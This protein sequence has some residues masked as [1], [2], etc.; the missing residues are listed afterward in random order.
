MNPEP[1]SREHRECPQ[2]PRPA[3][4][5]AEPGVLGCLARLGDI[6]ALERAAVAM[7]VHPLAA[8]CERAWLL[9][10]NARGELLE[11]RVS[12]AI[13]AAAPPL[14]EWI[15]RSTALRLRVEPPG[16][17]LSVRP[18]RLGGVAGQ[19]WTPGGSAEAGELDPAL[20]WAR[21]AHV[22]AVAL[23]RSGRPWGL[24][25][26]TW[27]DAPAAE[28][29]TALE[30][31]V[32]L[33]TQA[34]AA[35]DQARAAKWR[36][37][38]IASLAQVA[39]AAGSSLNLAEVLQ[40][41]V[42]QATRATGARG[43]ALWAS[44]NSGPRLE[45]MHGPVGSGERTA[46]LL[47]PLVQAVMQDGKVRPVDRTTEEML[48]TPEAAAD[49]DSVVVCPLRAYG[50]VLGALAVYAR[51]PLH[52]SDPSGF[53][54]GDVAFL[55]ALADVAGLALDQ[56]TRF[57]ELRQGEQER[58]ELRRR[59]QRQERLAWLGELAT[60]MAA[61]A[62]NP[63]ASISAF[64]RRV[65][66]AL[67]E[68]DP[69]REYL[70]IVLREGERLETLL[71]ESLGHAPAEGALGLEDLNGVVQEALDAVAETLVRRRVRLV[72]KL[73]TGLPTLLLDRERIRRVVANMLHGALEAVGV[74][75]RVRLESRG[76][77]AC[78]VL[79]VAHDGPRVPGEF[80][81]QLFAPFAGARPGAAGV[82]LAVAQQIVR[83]HGGEIRVRSDGEWSTIFSLS[84]PV[85][86]N[87]DRR[88]SGSDR[89][90]QRDRRAAPSRS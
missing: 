79:E 21:A 48:L 18:R 40:Q 83:E 76:L 43:S 70:E 45:A 5:L 67:P 20:P 26:G 25:V 71:E 23:R 11:E 88:R 81:E 29:R 74:G 27:R 24:I 34:A 14:G 2:A 84:L 78:V 50:R 12:D 51:V 38:Q 17:Q 77:G 60:R 32:A 57:A 33:C 87:Q 80:L 47:L 28:Q 42:R 22:G 9:V 10:W 1:S 68:N 58:R 37:Q 75:G 73:G 41:V 72:K 19:A 3:D 36:E 89:R 53:P 64:A 69:S 90:R 15:E 30:V 86:E 65:Q 16:G 56:A 85:H 66:R 49:V 35:L 44:S 54:A 46:H 6:E 31:A 59:L 4:A 61:E 82:G 13:P 7:A 62:R 55:S 52:P 8:G 63:L 39:Q